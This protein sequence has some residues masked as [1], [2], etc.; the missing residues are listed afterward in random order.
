MKRVPLFFLLFFSPLHFITHLTIISPLPFQIFQRVNNTGTIV[1]KGHVDTAGIYSVSAS[2][3]G[4][5]S[6]VLW[7]GESPDFQAEW[8]GLPVWQSDLV[9][10]V[11]G[12]EYTVPNVGIGDVYV[13]AGQSN[14]MGMGRHDQM[15]INTLGLHAGMLTTAGWSEL[16]DPTGYVTDNHA[17]GS[18]WP[19]LA[20]YI[21][22]SGVPVAFIPTARGGTSISQWQPGSNPFNRVFSLLNTL[23]AP[24]ARAILWQQGEADVNM[25]KRTYANYLETMTDAW[26]AAFNIPLFA[27]YLYSNGKVN[28]GIDL[29][30]AERDY[31]FHGADLRN[32][33]RDSGAHYTTDANLQAEAQRWFVALG[34]FYPPHAP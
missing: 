17:K 28:G 9:V 23:P 13:V 19:L 20:T 32:L 4:L 6:G 24:Y 34:S 18:Q 8:D 15:Y 22:E 21:L 27:A 5:E 33:P 16:A 10:T 26:H 31:I 25:A 11:A 3:N 30:V 7:E 29:A 12:T 1:I 2:W 14:A